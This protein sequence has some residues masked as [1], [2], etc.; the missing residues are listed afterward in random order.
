MVFSGHCLSYNYAIGTFSSS[1]TCAS[2]AHRTPVACLWLLVESTFISYL[3]K[4]AGVVFVP[5]TELKRK[6]CARQCPGKLHIIE[7]GSVNACEEGWWP[8]QCNSPT[9]KDKEFVF[10]EVKRK[11]YS[12]FICCLGI[13]KEMFFSGRLNAGIQL[14]GREREPACLLCSFFQVVKCWG[15]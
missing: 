14:W 4:D 5:C 11:R 8:S 1:I 15:V 12:V 3:T 13:K 2:Q 6:N 7:L 10:E 9:K